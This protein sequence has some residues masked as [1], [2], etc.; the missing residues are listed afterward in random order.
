MKG[1]M[2]QDHLNNMTV[3]ELKKFIEENNIP[4]DVDLYMDEIY[5]DDQEVVFSYHERLNQLHFYVKVK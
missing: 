4:D 2:E 5:Y 1:G 3:G